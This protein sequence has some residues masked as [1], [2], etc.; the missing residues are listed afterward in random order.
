ME[1]FDGNKC[2]R[3]S[4]SALQSSRWCCTVS[5]SCLLQCVQYGVWSA[6]TLCKCS[7]R[8]LCS[9]RSLKIVLWSLRLKLLMLSLGLGFGMCAYSDLPVWLLIQLSIHCC[10][11]LLC[12]M[13]FT[14]L[15][16]VGMCGCGMVAP[17]FAS[18][19]ERSLPLIS[20]C[21]GIHFRVVLMS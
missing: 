16:L 13:C 6:V 10:L 21:P 4:C 15:M 18:L 12:I 2:F 19:S 17:F 7:L 20:M 8:V 11:V 9:V 5:S 3:R 14:V 1:E